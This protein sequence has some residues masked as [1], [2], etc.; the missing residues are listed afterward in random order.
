VKVVLRR[1]IEKFASS[2]II[3]IILT[4]LRLAIQF[5][6]LSITSIKLNLKKFSKTQREFSLNSSKYTRRLW[7]IM[8]SVPRK[9]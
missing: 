8:N 6:T 5:P 1:M 4:R 9:L 2:D 7:I 3:K